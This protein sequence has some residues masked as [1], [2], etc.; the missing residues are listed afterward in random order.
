VLV[1]AWGWDGAE[2]AGSPWPSLI[3]VRHPGPASGLLATGGQ[4]HEP[5]RTPRRP[6]FHRHL[7]PYLLGPPPDPRHESYRPRASSTDRQGSQSIDREKRTR[8][9]TL[10]G[11]GHL[12]ALDVISH[13][14]ELM[15]IRRGDR[16]GR[17][18]PDDHPGARLST[19]CC[20]DQRRGA[21]DGPTHPPSPD[22]AAVSALGATRRSTGTPRRGPVRIVRPRFERAGS[23]RERPPDGVDTR[24]PPAP[25]PDPDGFPGVGP[26]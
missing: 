9:A 22:W 12:L 24:D 11:P 6:D 25:S 2:R 1:T 26:W 4:G 3:G 16:G 7:A 5:A 13:A 15:R 8:E 19:T 23:R 14:V 17:H 18:C 20:R 21:P 10:I